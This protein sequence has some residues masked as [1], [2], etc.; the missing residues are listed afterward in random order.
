MFDKMLFSF[1][2]WY[3]KYSVEIC[4][5]IIGVM[6]DS[7]LDSL[8][9]GRYGMAAIYAGFAVWNIVLRPRR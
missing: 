3:K 1:I 8:S 6:V 9:R 7:C 2:N 4:W 5:F